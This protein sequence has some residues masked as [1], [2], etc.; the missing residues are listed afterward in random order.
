MSGL[1][2]LALVLLFDTL[3]RRFGAY[4]AAEVDWPAGWRAQQLPPVDPAS[5]YRAVDRVAWRAVTAAGIPRAVSVPLWV[6]LGLSLAWS[7]CAALALGDLADVL[8]GT[9]SLGRALASL[10][11]ASL[12]LCVARASV[13]WVVLGAALAQDRARFARGSALAL[14]LDAALYALPLP[15]SDKRADDVVVAAWGIAGHLALA[16]GFAA[17]AWQRRGLEFIDPAARPRLN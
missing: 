2:V 6:V 4:G 15:C 7:L 3:A 12:A 5:P 16:I 1:V 13:G 10:A 9:R 11:L 8:R 17:S 14:A